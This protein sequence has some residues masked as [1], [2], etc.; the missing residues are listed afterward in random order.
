MTNQIQTSAVA[1]NTLVAQYLTASARE[2]SF[3]LHLASALWPSH[4]WLQVN[5]AKAKGVYGWLLVSTLVKAWQS[6]L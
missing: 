5:L 6:G 4:M 2:G 1:C 3:W